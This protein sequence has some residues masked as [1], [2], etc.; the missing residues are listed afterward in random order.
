MELPPDERAVLFLFLLAV[1]LWISEAVPA[2]AVGLLMAAFWVMEGNGKI[3]LGGV[4]LYAMLIQRLLWPV[5]NL[6]RILDDYERARA[7]ILRVQGIFAQPQRPA[8]VHA[9]PAGAHSVSARIPAAQIERV[10]ER[11]DHLGQ[12]QP[13]CLAA[14][15]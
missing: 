15:R 3:S 10:T 13:V 11:A 2:F 14:D 1:G 7:S 5:T 12:G 6:G 9:D 4:A 8:D